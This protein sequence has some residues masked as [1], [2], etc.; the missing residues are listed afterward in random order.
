MNSTLQL[1]ESHV[2]GSHIREE[3]SF[4]NA[5]VFYLKQNCGVLYVEMLLPF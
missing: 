4:G 1:F 2:K 3:M 5:L